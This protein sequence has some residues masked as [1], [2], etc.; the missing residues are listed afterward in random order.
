MREG[1]RAARRLTPPSKVHR[2]ACALDGYQTL[3][4]GDVSAE[5]LGSQP[6]GGVDVLA[7]ARWTEPA[8]S[9]GQSG[10]RSDLI[11]RVLVKRGAGRKVRQQA[12][13]YMG[14]HRLSP[15]SKGPSAVGAEPAASDEVG[16]ECERRP[17]L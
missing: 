15:A 9:F 5:E 14:A 10:E 8:L 2:K 16:E 17:S 12:L 11:G 7:V 3:F 13:R 4:D 6:G 1:A